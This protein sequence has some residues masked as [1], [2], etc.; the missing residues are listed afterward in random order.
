MG[1][2]VFTDAVAPNL[3][4]LLKN[5]LVFCQFFS[6]RN[7]R[8]FNEGQPIGD[9][10]RVK[11]PYRGMIRDGFQYVGAPIDRRYTTIVADQM[12]GID[13]DWDTIEK[14]IQM[15]RSME[16][17]NDNILDPLSAQLAQEFDSRAAR[18]AYLR[19]PNLAG[20][21]GTTPT[22]LSTYNRTRSKI[23]ELGGWDGAQRAAMIISPEMMA[24][25]V[26]GTPNVIGLF[27]P[28]DVVSKAFRK[29]YIGEYGGYSWFESMSLYQ[30]TSG[31]WATHGA[32][33]VEIDGANQAGN[34]ILIS[35]TTG[36]TFK[37]GDKINIE[38]VYSVNPMTRRSTLRLKEFTILQDTIGVASAATL[39]ISPA[40]IGPGSP[41]QNVDAL[42]ADNADLT[43]L[44][45]T[46][47]T[48]AAA[49]SGLFGQALTNEAFALVAIDLPMPKTSA[50][51]VVMSHTDD[52]TGI[53][54]GVI[55]WMDPETRSW[56]T[57][58]DAW[59]GFGDLLAENSACL[60]GSAQ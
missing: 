58:M 10:L 36:D 43:L 30:H 39:T 2:H 47:M 28:S 35:C 5:K 52:E 11:L 38:G 44:P 31:I 55:R 17:I 14:A 34:S 1:N 18:F 51:D 37:A 48:N 53:T 15:E 46:T 19:T 21:L 9:T 6:R 54:I 3:V 56:K 29:G 60:I 23:K 24:T 49:K 42:P 8:D 40:M 25:V 33:A 45:G 26:A 16:D 57:R 4:R 20:A 41:Y 32:N 59:I 13:V 22:A 12:F 27:N 7:E 50:F